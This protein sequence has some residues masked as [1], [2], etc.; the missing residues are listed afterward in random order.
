MEWKKVWNGIDWNKA[1]TLATIGLLIFAG[2]SLYL[3]NKTADRANDI[4]EELIRLTPSNSAY[5]DAELTYYVENMVSRFTSGTKMDDEG[6]ISITLFNTG[7]MDTG[8]INIRL[9]EDHRN[10]DFPTRR[11][12][13][14]PSRNN[15]DVSLDF[16]VKDIKDIVGTHELT[17]RIYCA[18]CLNQ[19]KILYKTI[20]FRIVNYS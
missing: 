16:K 12:E 10:F 2:W 1:Q 7:Q 15:S 18:N 13:N 14:I 6:I 8:S 11:I 4:S 3:S 20:Y 19:D 9:K 17:F 5:I